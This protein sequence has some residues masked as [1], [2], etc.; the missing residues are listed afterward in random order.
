MKKNYG[1]TVIEVLGSLVVI[2]VIAIVI[3]PITFNIV[4]SSLS[5]RS[6]ISIFLVLANLY[7]SGFIAPAI[8]I[9]LSKL[10]KTKGKYLWK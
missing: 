2:G 9:L 1:F 3:I 7:T 4:S 8:N 5:I 6:I 10:L